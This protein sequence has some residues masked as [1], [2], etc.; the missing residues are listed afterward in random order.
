[1]TSRAYRFTVAALS[2]S[3]AS[4]SAGGAPS[5]Q[6]SLGV[7]AGRVKPQVVIKQPT[8]A[9]ILKFPTGGTG[10]TDSVTV[11]G[12]K[13]WFAEQEQLAIG[14]VTMAGVVT[15]FDTGPAADSGAVNALTSGPTGG[16][17]AT[18]SD[19]TTGTSF[20]SYVSGGSVTQIPLPIP[21]NLATSNPPLAL[22]IAKGSD[23]AIWFADAANDAIGRIDPAT[24]QVTAEYAVPSGSVAQQLVQRPDGNVWF[25]E[26]NGSVGRLNP[27][28][29]GAPGFI[30]EIALPAIAGSPTVA[31][32]FA[33]AAGAVWFAFGGCN[34]AAKGGGGC[35]PTGVGSITVGSSPQVTLFQLTGTS[36]SKAQLSAVSAGPDGN[37]WFTDEVGEDLGSI[38][39]VGA[40]Q[41]SIPTG[42]SSGGLVTGP[43]KNIWFTDFDTDTIDVYI[44]NPQT[45]T[46]TSIAFNMAGE[47]QSIVAS[48][49]DYAGTLTIKP[50]C[51]AKV[52]TVVPA[53]S[54]GPG[55]FA[56]TVTAVAGGSCT[57]GVRDSN[58]NTTD[59]N[60]S[61]TTETFVV[62]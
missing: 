5:I 59:V 35:R 17:W 13:I 19:F 14:S 3:L 51:N 26:A 29:A 4:C 56:W 1:M 42:V 45:V 7:A 27:K 58:G 40:Y 28:L 6:T 22:G 2:C 9:Q 41:A 55:Q 48:E 11:L 50:A 52:A 37:I 47:T 62:D 33:N 60:V 54:P 25:N 20:V 49:E 12:G 15:E 53:A 43:D 24:D 30:T 8:G 61:V 23:K 10:N 46:P 38:T 31:Q 21:T 39:P 57:I 32:A 36:S 16:I 44:L 18:S 34:K